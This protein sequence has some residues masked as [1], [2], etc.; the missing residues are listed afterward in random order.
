MFATSNTISANVTTTITY[1]YM[2]I[3]PITVNSGVIITV[4][5]GTRW[6]VL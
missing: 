6:V 1:N 5:G 3:G 2:S 4:T